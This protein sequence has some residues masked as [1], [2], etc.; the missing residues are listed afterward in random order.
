[1][2]YFMIY[3]IIAMCILTVSFILAKVKPDL[4]KVLLIVSIIVCVTYIVWRF[5]TVPNNSILSFV[6]GII[7]IIAEII[8]MLQFFNFQYLFT[9][10]YVVERKT[11]A[12]FK[13]GEI[14][15]V[16][17]LIC[18]YNEPL[19]LVEKTLIA[20]LKMNYVKGKLKVYV[21]DDGKRY[22][23][24]A[25]C[26][27]YG[28]GYITREGNEGAKAGNINNALKIIKGDLFAVLDA[29]MIPKKNFL[30]RTVGY[31]SKEKLAFVQIPQVY[32]NQDMYQYNLDKHIPNEQDFFMRDIQAARASINAVLHI[33]TN[34]IFRKKYVDQ[35]G[36]YPTCSITEDMAVGMML[37]EEGYET[38]FI[39]E[40][41]VYGLSATTYADL[42]KQRDRWCRGNLQVIREFNP[43]FRKKLT[44][45]QKIAYI[46]GVIYW[47]SS[48]QKMVYMLWP[49]A[50]LMF[51]VLVLRATV[52]NLLTV[53]IPFYLG[54]I[55]VFKILSPGNRSIRWSH[56]YEVAMAPH[57][58]LSVIRELFGLKTKFN[59][60]PKDISNDKAYYQLKVALPHIVLVIL[61]VLSWCMGTYYILHGMINIEGYVINIAWGIYNVYGLLVCIR[62]AYQKPV[63][64]ATERVDL[65][66]P[67]KSRFKIQNDGFVACRILNISDEG[68]GI[69]LYKEDNAKNKTIEKVTNSILKVGEKLEMNISEF[70]HDVFIKG[71]VARIKNGII[72][73]KFDDLTPEEKINIMKI[74]VEN[75][76]AYHTVNRRQAY[77]DKLTDTEADVFI[78]GA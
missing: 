20:A 27:R 69:D 13:E 37:Q 50:Y 4:K 21:C 18:T 33:G 39:N 12:D 59:V 10:K 30:E 7:L 77:T 11:L 45:P 52:L 9:K 42:V 2:I 15:N 26:Q 1:M 6:L 22:S 36:G 54:Q 43:L 31:F 32:Y 65:K 23:M 29:D 14:P 8:G 44:L 75:L 24:K 71:T 55:L 62:V 78:Y 34:A 58:S 67:M 40:E 25:L 19:K 63:Y 5:T 46:D 56:I 64:R 49:M 48:I 74:Y 72:G 53:F 17:V 35:I 3:F 16:D 70:G 73:V 61:S 57:I 47:F 60:T 41:L 66:V 76:K 51:G 28:A 38:L 68:V